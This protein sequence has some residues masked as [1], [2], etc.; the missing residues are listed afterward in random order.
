MPPIPNLNPNKKFQWKLKNLNI[1][2]LKQYQELQIK[3][4][5]DVH[6][7]LDRSLTLDQLLKKILDFLNGKNNDESVLDEGVGG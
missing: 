6:K 3:F 1:E 7:C 5:K 4:Y 2:S